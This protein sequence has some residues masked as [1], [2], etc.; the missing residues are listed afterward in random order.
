MN[1][2]AI[3]LSG[4][5]SSRMGKNKALLNIKQKPNIERMKDE[6]SKLV[7]TII[8]VTNEPDEYQFLHLKTVKDE[9]PGKGPLA[10]IH[11]GL[12]AASENINL[13]AACDMP[14]VSSELGLRLLELAGDYDAVVPVINGEQQPLF[15]V[16]KKGILKEIEKCIERDHLRM[17]HLLMNINVLYVTEKDLTGYSSDRLDRIFFNM[18][19]PEEYENAMKWA[20][21]GE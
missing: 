18:N 14:F 7:N 17:K 10:G 13:I 19:H 12:K 15:A 20:E 21:T 16:Y 1:A 5:K 3:I 9:F 4:G 8:L 2:G 11:A 6:L